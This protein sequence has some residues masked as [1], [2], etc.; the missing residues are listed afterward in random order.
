MI[1]RRADVSALLAGN[2]IRRDLLIEYLH[3]IKDRYGALSATHLAALAEAMKLSQTEV[4]EVA[5]FYHHFD[6]IKEGEAPPPALTVRVCETLSCAMAGADELLKKLP[7]IL[8]KDVRVVAVRCIGRCE[9]APAVCVGQNAFGGATVEKITFAIKEKQSRCLPGKYINYCEYQSVGSY[10]TYFEFVSGKR[11]IESTLKEME[12]IVDRNFKRHFSGPWR[13]RA[14]R[15]RLAAEPLGVDSVP[16]SGA[17][18]A[19]RV[20]RR[21]HPRVN[22]DDRSAIA[23][24]RKRRPQQVPSAR[25]AGR[26]MGG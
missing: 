9:L 6:V 20:H 10:Q 13:S 21:G 23:G 8:G 12:W 14:R 5:T 3:L 18:L 2:T 17:E 25:G 7:A 4:Y 22:P 1:C 11:D 19:A 24:L 16:L 15:L 26:L